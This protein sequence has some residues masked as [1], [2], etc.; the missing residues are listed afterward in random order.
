MPYNVVKRDDEWCVYE[1]D[2]DGNRQGEPVACH[3]TEDLAN[4]HMSALYANVPD[5]QPS[6][7]ATEDI[8]AGVDILAHT[9]SITDEAPAT[10]T[11][12]ATAEDIPAKDTY[13]SSAKTTHP[14][15]KPD[16][17]GKSDAATAEV[18][19]TKGD[20]DPVTAEVPATKDDTAPVPAEVPVAPSSKGV[21]SADD[22]LLAQGGE[23]KMWSGGKVEGYLVRFSDADN[24]DLEMEYFDA[25][26][27]FALTKAAC[28]PIY[29]HHGQDPVLV[30]RVLC[31]G[32]M[33]LD[34]MGVWIEGQIK[35][36]DKYEEAV[37]TL[38]LGHKLSW[39][40]GT[41]PHLVERDEPGPKATRISRWP[42]GL[43]ASLTPTPA[44]PRNIADMKSFRAQDTPNLKA[45]VPKV[46]AE[47]AD[48]GRDE[49]KSKKRK[50]ERKQRSNEMRV[51]ANNGKWHVY[52]VGEDG[53][54]EGFLPIAS[55]DTEDEA[56]A[57]IT[58]QT[59][60]DALRMVELIDAQTKVTE[61]LVTRIE[62]MQQAAVVEPRRGAALVNV[63]N[64]GGEV[65]KTVNGKTFDDYMYAIVEND[66]KT[67]AEMG[68]A[69]TVS[70]GTGASGA[71]LVPETFIPELIRIEPEKEIVYPRADRQPVN[72]P[73]RLPGLSTAGQTAGRSNFMGGV[74]AVWNQSGTTKPETEPVFSQISLNP[75][76]LTGYVAVEDQLLSRSAINLPQLLTGLFRDALMFYRD[77]A[78]L[79]GTGAGQPLGI[80]NAPG[81]YIHSRDAAASVS[82]LDMVR[83]KGHLL[84]QS[85]ATA[86]WIF[87]ISCYEELTQMQDPNGSYIWQQNAVDGEPKTLLGLPY[88]F[89]EKTPILG[90]QGDVILA[91]EN[92]YYV[93]EEGGISIAQSEHVYFLQNQ[94]AFKFFLKVDG[95]EKLA[96]PVY[97]KDGSTEVSP[98]V[99]LGAAATT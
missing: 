32:I 86:H 85:W 50:T 13:R 33:K 91:D 19:A 51:Y 25:K 1:T 69:K 64:A 80:I 28:S 27:D 44:E 61:A 82:Y 30:K 2:E 95:Q 20:T 97:L 26:T 36:R 59:K 52:N 16:Q 9:H 23:V 79:D 35:L 29:Y 57:Y 12:K 45:L 98:F 47:K 89:T 75:W 42:L 58:D 94:T 24:P 7:A 18:P 11:S 8:S 60:P 84:P 54:P 68:A 55:Y 87:S 66:V 39:S 96:A 17:D 81:T 63:V 76:E 21:S 74:A 72:G 46:F 88:V 6:K 90:S 73:V 43:D 3:K 99:I 5:A 31:E 38:G 70:E 92:F 34:D 41:A 14:Y 77:E 40:S 37:Q 71:F 49:A 10:E 83:M 65:V 15:L 62:A 53:E 93:A 48:T 22:M 78:F 4:Y 67:L 56:K